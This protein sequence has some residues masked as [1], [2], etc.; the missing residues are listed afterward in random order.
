MGVLTTGNPSVRSTSFE[1]PRELGVSISEQDVLV[2]EASGDREVPRLLRDPGRV[3][4]TGRAGDV[5][6][7]TR[8]VDEGQDV[9]RLKEH[10]LDSEE[11]AREHSPPLRSEEL[12]PGRARPPRHRPQA[13]A[14]KDPTDRARAHS[15]PELTKLPLDPD[16]APPRVLPSEAC[17]QLDDLRTHGRSAAALVDGRST[18]AS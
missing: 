16:A 8:E 1:A 12:S 5:D 7:S 15:D 11:V 2:L 3:G 9:E 14:A 6:P 18:S 10:R 13:G 17:D 4:P